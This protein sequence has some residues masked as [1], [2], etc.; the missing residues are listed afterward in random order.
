MNLIMAALSQGMPHISSI[1]N[2]PVD[3]EPTV[4]LNDDEPTVTLNIANLES[5]HCQNKI[6]LISKEH[7]T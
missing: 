5:N 4:I 1:Y 6:L 2:R 3:D 7:A